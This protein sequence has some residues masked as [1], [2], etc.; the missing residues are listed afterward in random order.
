MGKLNPNQL[1][2]FMTGKEVQSRVTQSLD[3][4]PG[5]GLGE[6]WARKEQE[7]RVPG[8]FQ[9]NP[10]APGHGAGVYDSLAT[11]GYNPPDDR[12][13]SQSVALRFDRL[14][15][16]E[17]RMGWGHHRVAAAAALERDTGKQTFLPV[18]WL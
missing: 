1:K 5:E 16:D 3:T 4:Q 11:R 2:L 7:S 18:N 15:Q 13:V 10:D 9:T 6:M 14:N 12:E 17:M 8:N